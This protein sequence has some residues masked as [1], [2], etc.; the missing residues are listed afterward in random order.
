M[1]RLHWAF[2]WPFLAAFAIVELLHAQANEDCRVSK[3]ARYGYSVCLPNGWYQRQLPS[4][5][6]F[7]CDDIRGNCTTPVGGGPLLGHATISLLPAS[8]VLT[9]VPRDLQQFAH[10][11]ADKDPS[12]RFSE[13]LSISGQ[14]AA[15]KYIAVTQTYKTGAVNELPQQIVRY[16]VQADRAMV[17]IILAFNSGDKRSEQYRAVALNIAGSLAPAEPE[18]RKR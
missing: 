2:K 3:D 4:G 18:P 13:V 5:A 11:V 7:L 14:V 6:L 17:E 15:V 8:V 12:S 16:F 9:T 1:R 10:E